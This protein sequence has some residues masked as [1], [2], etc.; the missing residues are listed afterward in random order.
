MTSQSPIAL[1]AIQEESFGPNTV[2]YDMGLNIPQA[3]DPEFRFSQLDVNRGEFAINVR[4]M[5]AAVLDNK[6]DEIA[7]ISLVTPTW[8]VYSGK[9]K[10]DKTANRS[11]S[12]YEPVMLEFGGANLTGNPSGVCS[13]IGD[14]DGH[15]ALGKNVSLRIHSQR[16]NGAHAIVRIYEGTVFSLGWRRDANTFVVMVYRI[17]DMVPPPQHVLDLISENKK[18][19]KASSKNPA[20]I[21]AELVSI[22]VYTDVNTSSDEGSAA[23]GWDRP[24]PT[25]EGATAVQCASIL[26]KTLE[27]LSGPWIHPIFVESVYAIT[28]PR[29]EEVRREHLG[30]PNASFVR[31]DSTPDDWMP[32]IKSQV[33]DYRSMLRQ[34]ELKRASWQINMSVTVSFLPFSEDIELVA[35]L[36]RPLDEDCSP[37]SPL[38][39]STVLPANMEALPQGIEIGTN[40]VVMGAGSIAELRQMLTQQNADSQEVDENTF[41][42]STVFLR[43]LI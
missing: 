34:A 37:M 35:T 25:E 10:G 2:S 12:S 24:H 16:P 5:G 15:Q 9:K 39:I 1:T 33:S 6:L 18:S 23:L 31:I 32:E 41:E 26:Q 38:R 20:G 22:R 7:E 8:S 40:D 36:P 13:L 17:T 21:N 27:K 3:S 43:V 4:A 19:V 42:A 14:A 29:N 11:K 28:P 30:D